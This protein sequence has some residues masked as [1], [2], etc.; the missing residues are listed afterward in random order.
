VVDGIAARNSLR[1]IPPAR[2]WMV[3]TFSSVVCA[4]LAY[5]AWLIWREAGVARRR[6]YRALRLWGWQ[7]LVGA[8]WAPLLFTA[9]LRPAALAALTAGFALAALCAYRFWRLSRLSGMLMVPNLIW[10][11]LACILTLGGR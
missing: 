3:P 1:A 5:A 6:H 8:G 2:S 4:S 10:L 9:H 7:L 11:V